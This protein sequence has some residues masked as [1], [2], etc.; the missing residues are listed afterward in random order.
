MPRAKLA[1]VSV[2]ELRKEISRRQKALPALVA[3]RDALNCQIA[4]LEALGAVKPAA[5]RLGRKPGRKP[6]RRAMRAARPGSLRG[7]LAEALA[8]KKKLSVAEMVAAVRAAG[9]KSQSKFFPKVVGM[10]LAK[11]K[12]FKRISRGVYALRG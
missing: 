4:E 7:A 5:A 2:E 11:D 10:T 1:K 9:Y 12:R 3:K 6:G 8:S